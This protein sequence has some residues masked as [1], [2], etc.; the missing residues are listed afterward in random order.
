[1]PY[2]SQHSCRLKDPNLFEEGSIRTLHT[3]QEGLTLLAGKLKADGKS[4]TEGFRYDKK[5]WS[6]SKAKNHC[7]SHDGQFEPA[8]NKSIKINE[9]VKL[10]KPGVDYDLRH[11]N[12]KEL[13]A[14]HFYLHVAWDALK[15]G[16]KWGDWTKDE[17][18]QYHAKIIDVLRKRSYPMLPK[19]NSLDKESKTKE[20]TVKDLMPSDIPELLKPG[21]I[22]IFQ[23]PKTGTENFI[24]NICI[25]EQVSKGKT[26]EEARAICEQYRSKKIELVDRDLIFSSLKDFGSF[27]HIPDFVSIVGSTVQ[28]KDKEPNDIDIVIRAESKN[29]IFERKILA[30]FPEELRNKVHFI[31]YPAG[32]NS[33]Y[34]PIFD[35]VLRPKELKYIKIEEDY[36]FKKQY[37]DLYQIL[38][39]LLED[40]SLSG[41]INTHKHLHYLWNHT[42]INREDIFNAHSLVLNEYKRRDLKH[43]DVDDLDKISLANAF[44]LQDKVKE[45][46]LGVPFKPLKT[47]GGYGENEFEDANSAWK[48]WASGY[49]ELALEF[50]YDGNRE[51]AQK[52]KDKVY[53]FSEDTRRDSSKFLPWIVDEIKKISHD[54]ILDGELMIYEDGKKVPRKD[55]PKYIRSKEPPKTNWKPLYM[56]FDILYYDKPLNDLSWKERQKYLHEALPK[57]SDVIKKV[58]PTIVKNE[59]SFKKEVEHIRNLPDSEGV[60]AKDLNSVY[61]LT[62]STPDWAKIKNFKELH[63]RVTAKH[64]NKAGSFT[65]DVELSDGTPIGT[66]YVT[67]IDVPVSTILSV[68]VAEVK[69]TTDAKGNK[70]FSFDNPLVHH[71]EDPGISVTTPA[72]AEELSKYGRTKV[73]LEDLADPAQEGSEDRASAVQAALKRYNY[74]LDVPTGDMKFVYQH[75]WRGLTEEEA[76]KGTEDNIDESHSLHGDL[77]LNMGDHLI[78]YTI[79]LGEASTN[80]PK[81]KF[82]ELDETYKLEVALKLPQP[83]AWL[84]VEGPAGP[85]EV[86]ATTNK[87]ARHFI[88]DKGTY[89]QGVKREHF[90]EY[91]L[92]GKKLKGRYIFMYAPLGAVKKEITE[93]EMDVLFLEDSDNINLAERRVWLV[94]KPKD[95]KPYA[96]THKLEDVIAELKT[97][98]QKWLVWSSPTMKAEKIDVQKYNLSTKEIYLTDDVFNVLFLGTGPS[99]SIPREG[100]NDELCKDARKPGSKSKRTNS[101]VIVTVG[102]QKI[103]IDADKQ[104]I[105]QLERERIEE[106]DAVFQTHTH[107][108]ASGGLHDLNEWLIKKD[109]TS[110]PIYTE[111]ETWNKIT[112][113]FKDLPV[114]EFNEIKPGGIVKLP[115]VEITPFRVEHSTQ[116]G[117]PTLGF[118]IEHRDK[119]LLYSEDLSA[120]LLESEH[121]V[122]N[123]DVWILDAAMYFN[124]FIKGHLSTEKAIELGMK[125]KPKMLLL[126]QAGHTYPPYKKA[127]DEIKTYVKE[128]YKNTKTIVDLVYD[129]L[130][131]DILQI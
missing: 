127:I 70:K 69:V 20:E 88:E 118:R 117:F 108:D 126:T 22:P 25:E 82:I 42:N 41:L 71:K 131:V 23:G 52:E 36:P 14:D 72:K 98:K 124:T 125:Y 75:H 6:E 114:F 94:Q 76:T 102:D 92:E 58:I 4:A 40:L 3:K 21:G 128:N 96:E 12:T 83:K 39:S 15:S 37:L 67:N 110:I 16:K 120:L 10:K 1:M 129:G 119:V 84:T 81:D 24:F 112:K 56:V 103:L 49:K 30:Q 2:P 61:P 107:K 66:T 7:D 9:I 38:P 8:V 123:A 80:F 91:F 47:G 109:I 78:G 5:I 89:K 19:N 73:K 53:V 29:V 74:Y 33:S 13:F 86:G 31:Y 27:V 64:K 79:F 62:G 104:I 63:L 26:I 28:R 35:L 97:K 55:M 122:K 51:I 68:Y 54:V 101:S 113:N 93:D 57:D 32:P 77:R 85:G 43:Q 87:W 95:Q 90:Q 105:E 48:Y 130:K 18:L 45:I 121:F 116:P 99:T 11:T 34:V 106:I 46:K 100:C 60:M 115:K 50:K 59:S 17:V 111:K 65:Y 44:N